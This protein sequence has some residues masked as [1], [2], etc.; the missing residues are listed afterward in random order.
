[1]KKSTQRFAMGLCL[2]LPMLFGC[3]SGT[4]TFLQPTAAVQVSPDGVELGASETQQFTATVINTTDTA[5]T[6]TLSGCSGEACGTITASGLYTAPSLIVNTATVTVTAT[7]QADSKTAGRA[8]VTHAPL[9]VAV[10]PLQPLYLGART[11]QLFTASITRHSNPDVTWN[12]SGTGCTGDGCGTLAGVTGSS[13]TYSAPDTIPNQAV[14]LVKATSVADTSKSQSVVVN[15]MPVS[16]SLNSGPQ[17]MAAPSGKINFRAIVQYDPDNAGVS[18]SLAGAGCTDSRCGTLKGATPVSVVYQAPAAP[19]DPPTVTLTARS[20]TNNAQSAAST[21]TVS[22]A[23]SALKG[24]YAFLIRGYRRESGAV[25]ME[26]MA[27]HF[28][29]DGNGS[30]VGVWDANRGPV[31]QTGQ[32]ITGSYAVQPDGRGNLTIDAG[33]AM[34]TFNLTVDETGAIARLSEDT[35]VAVSETQAPNSDFPP[36]MRGS[37]GFLARQ[38]PTS[39]ALS[40][41]GGDRVIALFG[42]HTGSPSVL[43]GRFTLSPAGVLSAGAADLSW[44]GHYY[45]PGSSNRSPLS[46]SFSAPDAATGRG[47]IALTSNQGV[48][49]FAYY[50]VSNRSVL[51]VQTDARGDSMPALSGEV[52][53]QSGAGAFDAASLNTPLIFNLSST[54]GMGGANDIDNAIFGNPY[55]AIYMGQILPNGDG[56]LAI[57]SDQNEAGTVALDDTLS[58][59]YTVE[60]NGRVTFSNAF[61]YL[62][63]LNS[64]YMMRVGTQGAQFG[65]FEPRATGTFDLQSLSGT[66]RFNTDLPPTDESL[67]AS[68]LLKLAEDG[69]AVA[70]LSGAIS[71]FSGT[72]NVDLKGRGVLTLSTSSETN[73]AHVVIWAVSPYHCIALL[74]ADP[75]YYRPVL[76]HLERLK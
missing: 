38:D 19:P 28:D 33:T 2:L 36:D 24:K 54:I 10:S 23:L 41:V 26:T 76:M 3:G 42:N 68:G 69:T 45:L 53:L 35:R 18:W 61:A 6:W 4:T 71:D 22:S 65:S 32:P 52:R 63:G 43:L 14:V 40:S 34:L 73:P 55:P 25:T 13:A 17:A 9:S 51:L 48:F 56:W 66:F 7:L 16:V 5:V 67:N 1:M 8:T 44:R 30:L 57:T 39:F 46:G 75:L 15:L 50:I 31:P 27:G 74:R 64:G 21:I 62:T 20:V 49:N 29:A 37:S 59:D 58:S 11:T 47:G 70:S 60:T 12:L 72:L